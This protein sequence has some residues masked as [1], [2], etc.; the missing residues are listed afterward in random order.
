MMTKDIND[1]D[2]GYDMASLAKKFE[3]EYNKTYEL[4]SGIGFAYLERGK[5]S[6]AENIFLNNTEFMPF[7]SALGL[8]VA[9]YSQGNYP[10]ALE[11]FKKATQIEPKKAIAWNNKG[12]TLKRMGNFSDAVKSFDN[13]IGI[14]S[15]YVNAWINK[16]N[17][18]AYL[19]R[20]EGDNRSRYEEALYA[21]NESIRL[22][23]NDAALCAAAWN[24]KCT[25]FNALGEFNESEQA[26]GK[27]IEIYPQYAD[28]WINK[29]NALAY[30]G[31]E[32]GDNRSRYEE[33][34][35]AY[36]ESIRLD[37][38]DANAWYCKGE[39]LRMIRNYD[40]ALNAYNESI[41]INSN[42]SIVWCNK[43]L[44]LLFNEEWNEAINC[45]NKSIILD[46]NLSEAWLGK[47]G[48][49]KAQGRDVEAQEAYDEA[50]RL[51]PTLAPV[52]QNVSFEKN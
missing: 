16:G 7:E 28:V 49:L 6:E 19:G 23:P 48:A 29:G 15:Q 42:E 12:V 11:A 21:Y 35:Y 51:N 18:L 25:V 50:T 17:A 4:L 5:Y 24:G 43:G 8:G 1:L 14:N 47:C 46:A 34:L 13:A 38:N 30:L 41:K 52:H 22:D 27:A 36:N 26:C 10:E 31:R 37:P 2:K 3:P 32:E 20:E 9:Y 40:E 44:A 45:F 39:F 33:A